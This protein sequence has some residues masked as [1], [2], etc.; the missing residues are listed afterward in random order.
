MGQ[1]RATVKLTWD[2]DSPPGVQEM[3]REKVV[4]IS[5]DVSRKFVKQRQ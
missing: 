1:R 4:V 3:I 2:L 5:N